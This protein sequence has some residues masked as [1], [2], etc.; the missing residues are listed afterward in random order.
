MLTIKTT[1][2]EKYYFRKKAP[3]WI[4]DSVIKTPLVM[5]NPF[6]SLISIFTTVWLESKCLAELPYHKSLLTTPFM[7]KAYFHKSQSNNKSWLGGHWRIKNLTSEEPC[8]SLTSDYIL[9]WGFY[10]EQ[11]AN[12]SIFATVL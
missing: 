4:F 3:P 2:P 6:Y 1:E 12:L 8:V 5:G 10:D 11:T 7:K 9:K